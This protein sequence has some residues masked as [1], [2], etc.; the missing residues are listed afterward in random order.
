[1]KRCIELFLLEIR[2]MHEPDRLGIS[3]GGSLF[4]GCHPEDVLT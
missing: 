4:E 3:P 2:R 1:M